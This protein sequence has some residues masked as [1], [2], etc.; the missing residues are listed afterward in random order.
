[1]TDRTAAIL[2]AAGITLA[3]LTWYLGLSDALH[4]HICRG[5]CST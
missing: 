5:N 3:L 2:V 1:M 4:T